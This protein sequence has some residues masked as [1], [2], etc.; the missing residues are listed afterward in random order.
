MRAVVISVA[1][2]AVVVGLGVVATSLSGCA[3]EVAPDGDGAPPLD[4]H[5][6]V[7]QRGVYDCTERADTGYTDGDPFP[8]TVVTVDG[9]PVERATANAYLALQAAADADGIALRI[10][11][12]FRTMAEQEYFYG[13]YVDCNCNNCNLAARPGYSN[14]Q[15]GHALDLNTSDRGVLSWLND[16]GPDFG[17]ERT[18]PSENWHWEWWGDP[19]DHPGPCGGDR[20][21]LD[22]PGLGVC[23]GDSAVRCDGDRLA[24]TDCAGNGT[25]CSTAGGVPHCVDP[26][27]PAHLD[28]AEDGTFC[29]G[30]GLLLGTC[31][32]GVY[33][34]LDCGVGGGRCST[35]GDG[36]H[37]VEGTCV[38]NLD[39]AENGAF[40]RDD[41]TL[42]TCSTGVATTTAC[43]GSG[44]RCR[45][46]RGDAACTAED[47]ASA[48]DDGDDTA[49]AD[50]AGEGDIT[51]LTFAPSVRSGCTQAPAAAWALLALLAVR[52]RTRSPRLR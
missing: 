36:G 11:S 47:P 48:D 18:V 16:R 39:G 7:A 28:G 33:R 51:I 24:T 40:C 43:A 49:G 17:W 9:R 19:S 21:C 15:S 8:I 13:C 30:D 2:Q 38:T 31:V 27:C 52:R 35:A 34:A 12:G 4:T 22:D 44:G 5:D 37:C 3:N 42:V 25:T 26:A 23:E 1:W 29:T 32:G 41:D 50:G 46:D 10:V 20:R 45:G 6:N 14:H